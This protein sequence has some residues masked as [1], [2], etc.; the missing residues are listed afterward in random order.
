MLWRRL[1]IVSI[2]STCL[3]GSAFSAECA[4]EPAKDLNLYLGSDSS[5]SSPDQRWEFISVAAKS[6][7]RRAALYI[8]DAQ[9]SKKW[10]IGWIE[11]RGT[12]FWS[13]DSR[14]LFLRDEYAA[15]DTKIRV[16]DVS[17]AAP[18]QIKG[19]D[20]EIRRTIFNRIPLNKTT[21]WLYYPK[22]CFAANDSSTIIVVADAPLVP[23]RESG[24]GKPFRL[25]LTVNLN[26]LEIVDSSLGT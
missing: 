1:V 20:R 4:S 2:F 23:K 10:N 6:S 12:A 13:D 25:K 17:G 7:E 19:V 15:D 21:Q 18:K 24:R 8:Q 16:F 9:R 3:T 26:P 22:V 14:W 11:R 5:L